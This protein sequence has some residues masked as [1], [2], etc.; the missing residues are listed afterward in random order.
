M[1]SAGKYIFEFR[2]VAK[3][4]TGSVCQ[5]LRYLLEMHLQ[6]KSLSG[7]AGLSKLGLG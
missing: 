2:Y 4:A 7:E 1:P 6:R 3:L 5:K